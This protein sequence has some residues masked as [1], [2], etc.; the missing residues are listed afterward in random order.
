MA[1]GHESSI[2]G[3]GGHMALVSKNVTNKFL[4]CVKMKNVQSRYSTY[5]PFRFMGK[6]EAE[7]Y[8]TKLTSVEAEAV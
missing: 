1:S 6:G 7:L 5:L 8:I 2:E 4:V 3:A